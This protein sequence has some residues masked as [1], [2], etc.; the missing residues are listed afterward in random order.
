MTD[1]QR[2]A[3]IAELRQLR[4]DAAER[5]EWAQS[6]RYDREMWALIKTRQPKPSDD[7]D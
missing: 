7:A 5:H 3:R 1:D 4:A 6:I 2:E